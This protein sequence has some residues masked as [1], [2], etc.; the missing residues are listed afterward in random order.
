MSKFEQLPKHASVEDC[1]ECDNEHQ[2][3]QNPN[4]VRFARFINK[5][6]FNKVMLPLAESDDVGAMKSFGLSMSIAF[7][8]IFMFVLPWFFS[9]AIP[10]W[11]LCISAGLIVLYF[12]KAAL[13]YYPYV[14]WMVIASILGFINTYV[15]LFVIYALMIVPI[16]VCMRVLGKLQFKHRCAKSSCW[17]QRDSVPNKGNL[18][19]P[20]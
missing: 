9:H 3:N 2:N 10:L 19:E 14:L 13:L 6:P 15:I 16:G 12:S 7:P 8:A 18:K 5:S 4:G 20:F 11:P 17:I 1:K